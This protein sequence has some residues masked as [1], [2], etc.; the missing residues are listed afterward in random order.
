MGSVLS[1]DPHT[2]GGAGWVRSDM[3][4]FFRPLAKLSEASPGTRTDTIREGGKSAPRRGRANP[5]GCGAI[6]RGR[7]KHKHPVAEWKGSAQ[8]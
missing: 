3:P 7:N 8:E 2:P 5:T 4:G 6:V 1:L